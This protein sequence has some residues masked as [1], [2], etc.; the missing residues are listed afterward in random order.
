MGFI[1]NAVNILAIES[2]NS[3]KREFHDVVCSYLVLKVDTNKL[4]ILY[5]TLFFDDNVIYCDYTDSKEN[6]L[7]L[8]VHGTQYSEI[9]KSI[10]ERLSKLDGVESVKEYPII[11]IFEV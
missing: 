5:P 6:N 10:T 7:I 11:N 3:A 9:T 1:H 2:F 8:L 4:D